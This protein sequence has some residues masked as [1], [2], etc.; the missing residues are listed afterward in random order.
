[1]SRAPIKPY[2]AADAYNAEIYYRIAEIYAEMTREAMKRRS[3]STL[4]WSRKFNDAILRC[5]KHNVRHPKARKLL[6]QMGGTI[7]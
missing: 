4:S 1:V 6:T 3:A 5:L 7:R 2:G